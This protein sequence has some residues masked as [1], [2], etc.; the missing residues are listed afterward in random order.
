LSQAWSMLVPWPAAGIGDFYDLAVALCVFGP[1][2]TSATP[3]RC[4][5]L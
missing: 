1:E 5:L 3:P 4:G 2:W